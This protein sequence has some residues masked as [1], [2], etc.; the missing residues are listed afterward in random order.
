MNQHSQQ[1]QGNAAIPARFCP[2]CTKVRSPEGLL[3]PECGDALLEQGYCHVCE[4]TW[5]AQVGEHCPKHEIAL[6]SLERSCEQ[7]PED[8]YES[9]SWVTV[10]RVHH[11]TGA[12]APRLRLEAEG[13]ATFLEGER[14]GPETGVAA[15]GLRL[16]VPDAL[17]EQAIKILREVAD[18]RTVRMN[19]ELLEATSEQRPRP[20]R[21]LGIRHVL[22]AI[23][24]LWTLTQLVLLFVGKHE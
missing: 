1:R 12:I 13:I 2:R 8:R 22:G 3:C 10:L 4:S 23:L 21:S 6:E 20:S 7:G 19:S 11:P 15:G 14:L 17:A 18:S 9:G 24:V 16:Q 5:R